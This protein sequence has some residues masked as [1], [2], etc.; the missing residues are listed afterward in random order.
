MVSF[1]LMCSFSLCVLESCSLSVRAAEV[2]EERNRPLTPDSSPTLAEGGGRPGLYHSRGFVSNTRARAALTYSGSSL[3]KAEDRPGLSN[4]QLEHFTRSETRKAE[5][6]PGLSNAQL[7]H[8]T[9]SET[10]K[11]EDRLGLSNAQL[12]H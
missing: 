6:R 9:R 11:T 4:A 10:C 3:C 8:F 1:F 12:Q 2:L 7:E 5:G